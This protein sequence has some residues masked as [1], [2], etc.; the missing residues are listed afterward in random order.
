MTIDSKI[1]KIIYSK[2]I[3][4]STDSDALDKLKEK[5]AEEQK[6]HDEMISYNKQARKDKKEVYPA[7]ILSNSNQRIKNI[8]D[9]ISQL[10]KLEDT[11]KGVPKM[12]SVVYH[13]WSN[14][15]A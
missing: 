9:R 13:K 6:A 1:D 2:K 11:P 12:P 10:E 14:I 8:K 7:Y 5:L 4:K 3:I 15:S